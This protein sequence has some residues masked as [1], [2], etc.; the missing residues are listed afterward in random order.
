MIK[1]HKISL[2]IINGPDRKKHPTPQNMIGFDSTYY[3]MQRL[4][5]IA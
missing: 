1:Q 4:G 3:V 5:K 2:R